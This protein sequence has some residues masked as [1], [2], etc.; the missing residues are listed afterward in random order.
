M[1]RVFV[2]YVAAQTNT[3]LVA[4]QPGKIIRV[5]SVLLTGYGG[6]SVKLISD[7]GGGSATDVSPPMHFGGTE[8]LPLRLGRRFALT[9][10]RGKALGFTSAFQSAP[11]E[12]SLTIWYEVVD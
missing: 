7:P 12:Y 1:E 8:P 4:A 9:T 2:S 6:M 10:E 11:A 3:Q 5:L